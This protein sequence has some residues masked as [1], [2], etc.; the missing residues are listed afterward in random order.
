MSRSARLQH[1]E[2]RSEWP[3][4]VAALIF[5]AAYAWP[6]L[7]PDV[8]H[9]VRQVCS[10]VVY[11]VWALFAVDFITRVVLSDARWH[12][13][14]HHIPDLLSV[15]LPVLR[16]L[17]LLRLVALIRVLNRR[18]T[19]SLQGQVALYVSSSTVLILLMASLAV[20]DAERG[21]AGSN[22]NS[23]GDALWWSVT[24]MTTVGYGD[25]YPVTTQGRFVA[26]GL[27]VGGIALIGVVTASIASW[28]IAQVRSVEKDAQVTLHREIESMQER[29]ARMEAL[30]MTLSVGAGSTPERRD[31]YLGDESVPA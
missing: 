4:A 31:T 28:L 9:P 18:A 14:A 5:L 24:T 8:V 26:V 21:K 16:P 19:S 13:I 11:A 22:I 10:I 29:L 6:I 15:A 30:L 12:F 17:R 3:L 20:L 27:M 2:Q 23:V 7:Q 25:H 1:W